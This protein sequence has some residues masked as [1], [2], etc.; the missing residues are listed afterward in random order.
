MSIG[1]TV[2]FLQNTKIGIRAT[3]AVTLPLVAMLLFA[4]SVVWEKQRVASEMEQLERMAELAPDV[5]ALVHELQKER[6]LSAGFIGSGGN[7]FAAELMEQRNATNERNSALAAA[8]GD[9]DVAAYGDGF[10]GNVRSMQETLAGLEQRRVAVSELG[11]AVPEMAGYYSG[12]IARL[13]GIVEV[14]AVISSDSQVT[15]AI[16]A[17]TA[18][19]QAKERAG[20]ERAMGTAGFSAGEFNPALYQRF[21]RLIAA[22]DTLLGIFSGYATRHEVEFY[23]STMAGPAVEEVERMRTIALDSIDTGSTGGIEGAYWFDTITRKID[24]M[25]Q[26][27]DQLAGDLVALAGGIG[28]QANSAF[29]LTLAVTLVVFAV[30]VAVMAVLVRGIT[31]PLGSV[32]GIIKRLSEGDNAVEVQHVDRGDEIGAIARAVEVFKNNA[33]EMERLREEQKEAEKRAE[34]EKR[35]AMQQLANSFEESVKGIVDGVSAAATEM[36]STAETMSQTADQT[37][38]RTLAVSSAAEQASSNVQTV[39][40]ASEELAGSI[41]E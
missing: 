23:Q 7:K 15:N 17:Y 4:G 25:K 24:L 29:M 31:R 28:E 36:Q 9:F 22:Q 37:R 19:L 33:V 32:T 1:K 35:Q 11:T 21:I 14:M 40:S 3:A 16:T 34:A 38:S 12:L 30:T 2:S 10:V 27:E 39:A 20:L 6:G 8:L 13:L 18:L 26:V 41:Q 5:S